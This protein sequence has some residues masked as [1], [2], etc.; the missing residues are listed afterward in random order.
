MSERAL[1]LVPNPDAA[2]KRKRAG[3]NDGDNDALLAP[4]SVSDPS[5]ALVVP[6]TGG[7]AIT[8]AEYEKRLKDVRGAVFSTFDSVVVDLPPLS[9]SLSLSSSPSLSQPRP[10]SA[11]A[12]SLS[13]SLPLSL[14]LSPLPLRPP[15]SLNLANSQTRPPAQNPATPRQAD[16]LEQKLAFI[17]QNVPTIVS[18]VQ[19]SAAGAGSGTFHTYANGRR[20]EAERVERMEREARE[21][22]AKA[23][24]EVGIFFLRER[25]GE[26]GGR[27]ERPVAERLSL[28]G[29]ERKLTR[30][31]RCLLI[32]FTQKTDPPLDAAA[33]R[34]GEDRKEAREA[35]KAKGMERARSKGWTL[36]KQTKGLTY[37]RVGLN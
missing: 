5:L 24:M 1:A 26:G 30:L 7:P 32:P 12:L 9:L 19:G 11:G 35:A 16:E 18:N 14:S 3:D 23:E 37:T 27:G 13:L 22:A 10:P 31:F 33:G 36:K 20:R 25:G 4:G 6:A 34:G 29:K 28:V 15:L 17:T 2:A 21:R 8:K